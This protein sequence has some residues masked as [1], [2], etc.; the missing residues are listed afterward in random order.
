M[1]L[2]HGLSLLSER[3]DEGSWT[4]PLEIGWI[5]PESNPITYGV[6]QVEEFV[7]R[8]TWR[9]K[10][11]LVV[12]AHYTGESCLNPVHQLGMPVLGRVATTVSSL[13]NHRII[14]VSGVRGCFE[15]RKRFKAY[16]SVSR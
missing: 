14:R 10:L 13:C 6:A 11:V 9:P 3:V 7:K 12:D 5:P 2:G 4:L 15:P 1:R 16:Q 8:H